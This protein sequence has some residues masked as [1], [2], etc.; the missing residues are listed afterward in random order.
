MPIPISSTESPSDATVVCA[1]IHLRSVC[2]SAASAPQ[3]SVTPP[4]TQSVII[5]AVV[6]PSI[7]FMRSSR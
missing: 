3:I 1:S 7:G 5:H 2:R 6:P 4:K